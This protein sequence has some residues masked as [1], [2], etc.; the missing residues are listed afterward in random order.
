LRERTDEIKE[1]FKKRKDKYIRIHGR[2]KRRWLK[3]EILL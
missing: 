3:C 2:E 1:M